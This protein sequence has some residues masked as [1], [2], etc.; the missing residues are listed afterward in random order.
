M[1]EGIVTRFTGTLL[2]LLLIYCE[3]YPQEA[4]APEVRIMFYNVENLFDTFDDTLTE[5]DE[6]LPRGLRRWNSRRYYTKISSLFKTITAAGEWNP[7]SVIGLCEIENKKVLEDLIYGTNLSKYDYGILHRNSPDPR[8]IDVCLVYRKDVVAIISSRFMIPFITRPD[9]FTSRS[10]LYAKCLIMGDTVHLFVNHWPS[11]RGGV[12]AGE[13]QRLL[14]AGMVRDRADSIASASG[15]K[16]RIIM[17]GDFNSTPDD[18]I[19]NLLTGRYGS[20]LTMIN[21]AAD[22]PS[23]EGSYRYMGIWELIDQAIVSEYFLNCPGGLFTSRDMFRVFRPEFLLIKDA[24]Y[25]GKSPFS[26][27]SGY[28]YRGGYSDHLPVLLDLKVR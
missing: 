4:S 10:V 19:I 21:L 25:P 2:L 23:Q 5:D 11:R 7:P 3:G 14:I 24:A 13:A 6:F 22:K 20:G 8:G 16:A 18:N 26:T 1:S 17:M 15:G 12:L 27:Y 9:Q 28:R